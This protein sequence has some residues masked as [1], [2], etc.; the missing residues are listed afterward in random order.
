MRRSLLRFL[1][2]QRGSLEPRSSGSAKFSGVTTPRRKLPG[3]EKKISGRTIHTFLLANPNLED[4]I[5]LK[6]GRFVTSQFLLN[7]DVNRIIQC[8]SYFFAF[9]EFLKKYSNNIFHSRKT[10][11]RG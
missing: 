10:N 3:K 11:E 8:I 9:L 6:G 4:E 7:L 1:R 5:H 2:L